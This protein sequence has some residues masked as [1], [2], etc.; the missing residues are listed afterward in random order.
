MRNP[1]RGTGRGPPPGW[2]SGKGSAIRWEGFTQAQRHLDST[3]GHSLQP[4]IIL[5]WDTWRG[6]T[7]WNQLCRAYDTSSLPTRDSVGG[8]QSPWG[9]FLP[10]PN[11]GSRLPLP[12]PAPLPAFSARRKG[13]SS[14]RPGGLGWD[15][16]PPPS[17]KG[18]GCRVLLGL[19]GTRPEVGLG[20][21]SALHP[22]HLGTQQE[23]AGCD[24]GALSKLLVESASQEGDGQC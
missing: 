22:H 23:D 14:S 16:A 18:P 20:G 15:L 5:T 3:E 8:S 2:G 9:P 4:P 6:K 1:G 24:A 12:T 19:N 13:Q 7:Q 21:S 10:H 17:V 11:S